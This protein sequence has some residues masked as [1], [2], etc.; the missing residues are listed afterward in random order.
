ML[1]PGYVGRREPVPEMDLAN[2]PPDTGFGY[3]SYH[4]TDGSLSAQARV[5]L[6]GR[7]RTSI[8]QP[9]FCL[10]GIGWTIQRKRAEQIAVRDPAPYRLAVQR[11]DM[12]Q[13]LSTTDGKPAQRAGVYVFWFVADGQLTASHWT[14]TAW[15]MRDLL[16]KNVLQRWAYVSY[17]AA[18]APGDEDVTFDRLSKL[19]AASVPEFQLAVGRTD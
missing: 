7:D 9:E 12:T 10:T 13:S 1:V 15:M 2:L 16:A 11:F 14:R 17:F 8:H 4:A 18:C 6:M 3:G 19:I 5:V